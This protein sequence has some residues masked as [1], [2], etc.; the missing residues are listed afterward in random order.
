MLNGDHALVENV[1]KLNE[2]LITNPDFSSKLE[3]N[4][5]KEVFLSKRKWIYDYMKDASLCVAEINFDELL[6][7]ESCFSNIKFDQFL[8]SYQISMEQNKEITII[9]KR[10]ENIQKGIEAINDIKKRVANLKIDIEKQGTKI[11]PA[12]KICSEKYLNSEN[13][14][15]ATNRGLMVKKKDSGV[16]KI[17]DGTHRLLS[18]GLLVRSE[19]LKVKK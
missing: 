8:D 1:K 2:K 19:N 11:V 7:F 14:W 15:I 12:W 3:N 17:I 18:Y 6:K 4:L 5:R 16:V 10:K 13:L 9:R